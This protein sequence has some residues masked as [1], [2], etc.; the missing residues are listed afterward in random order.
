MCSISSVKYCV[1]T[2]VDGT[3]TAEQIKKKTIGAAYVLSNDSIDEMIVRGRDVISGIPKE[4]KRG[5][6][7]SGSQCAPRLQDPKA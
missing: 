3:I 1:I 7:I 2:L 5:T 4:I 6:R